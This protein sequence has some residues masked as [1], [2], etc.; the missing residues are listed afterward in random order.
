MNVIPQ[1]RLFYKSTEVE[2]GEVAYELTAK[3]VFDDVVVIN[4]EWSEDGKTGT[5]SLLVEELEEILIRYK[6]AK[7]KK[8][9]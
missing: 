7:K 5:I 1:P 8:S 9:K 4:Q 3:I 6:C 2:E